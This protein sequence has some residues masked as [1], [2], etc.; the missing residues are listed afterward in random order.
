MLPLHFVGLDALDQFEARKSRPE[1]RGVGLHD[2]QKRAAPEQ[3]ILPGDP[4]TPAAGFAVGDAL[5]VRAQHLAHGCHHFLRGI[6]TD[7]ADEMN[8]C[9]HGSAL[10]SI[11]RSHEA[12]WN[13][14][15]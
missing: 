12:F 6:E 3:R 10:P 14:T 1:R 15:P 2:L 11:Q 8:G 5:Q 7:A 4:H 13:S 9:R